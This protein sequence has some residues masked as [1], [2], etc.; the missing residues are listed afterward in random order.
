MKILAIINVSL[1]LALVDD[2]VMAE[3]EDLNKEIYRVSLVRLISN[4]E[5]YDGKRVAVMGYYSYSPDDSF[6]YLSRESLENFASTNGFPVVNAFDNS[7]GKR[8]DGVFVEVIGEFQQTAQDTDPAGI[9]H[10]VEQVINAANGDVYWE[11]GQPELG[12]K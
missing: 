8:I 3:Q 9:I 10:G 5:F 1:L 12:A 6:I 4:S 7:L 2:H 11:K